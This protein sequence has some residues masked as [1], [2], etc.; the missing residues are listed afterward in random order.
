MVMESVDAACQLQA[1]HQ[2][3]SSASTGDP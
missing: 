3:S 1:E 2:P